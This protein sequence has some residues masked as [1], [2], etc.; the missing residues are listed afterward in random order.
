MKNIDLQI[1]KLNEISSDDD[2]NNILNI[3]KHLNFQE[4]KVTQKKAVNQIK[5][6]LSTHVS[7][8][9]SPKN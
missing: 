1:N 9:T 8:I 3:N 5:K 7:P 4:E 2:L 6:S